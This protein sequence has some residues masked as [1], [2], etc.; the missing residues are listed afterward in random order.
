MKNKIAKN[1][2]FTTVDICVITIWIFA[3][4]GLLYTLSWIGRIA[5]DLW[6]MI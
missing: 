1:K 4:I 6:N 2:L 5:I 3:V